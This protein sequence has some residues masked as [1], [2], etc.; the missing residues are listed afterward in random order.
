MSVSASWNASFMWLTRRFSVITV[1]VSTDGQLHWGE[2]DDHGPPTSSAGWHGV[3]HHS[4][5]R[6]RRRPC[7][8][9]HGA[10]HHRQHGGRGRHRSHSG[11]VRTRGSG[12]IQFGTGGR[13]LHHINH[14]TRVSRPHRVL[15]DFSSFNLFKCAIENL[16]LSQYLKY[17]KYYLIVSFFYL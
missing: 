14:Q 9:R 2:E 17:D 5:N 4:L 11:R 7:R 3:H 6:C 15:T 16:D 10:P 1:N 12:H 13:P 8:H